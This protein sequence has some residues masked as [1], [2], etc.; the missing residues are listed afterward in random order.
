[1]TNNNEKKEKQKIYMTKYRLEN[2]NKWYI[3]TNCDV[4]KGTYKRCGK[5]NHLKTLK[6]KHAELKKKYDDLKKEGLEKVKII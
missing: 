5:S 2:P 4:C 3:Q 1:M 6:H